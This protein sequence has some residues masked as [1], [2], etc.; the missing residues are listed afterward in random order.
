MFDL[1]IKNAW[2]VDGNG[3][4]GFA[5]D[6]AVRDGKI[7]AIETAISDQ[8]RHTLDAARQVVAPGFIDIQTHYDA[9]VFWDPLCSSSS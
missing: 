9:Q 7:A 6:V 3:P 4:P 5:G 1:L 8:A 2:I